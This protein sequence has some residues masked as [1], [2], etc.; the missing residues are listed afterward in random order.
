MEEIETYTMAQKENQNPCRALFSNSYS[1]G[2]QMVIQSYIRL[3]QPF[4][5]SFDFKVRTQLK[6]DDKRGLISFSVRY[7]W[8]YGW[9]A[10][11]AKAV[12]ITTF[13]MEVI[14]PSFYSISPPYEDLLYP[15][16]VQW[17]I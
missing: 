13:N 2:F 11:A 14:S 5:G 1:Q 3:P 7:T 4:S 8:H 15:L 10:L 12:F 16:K 17:M 6:D 9:G